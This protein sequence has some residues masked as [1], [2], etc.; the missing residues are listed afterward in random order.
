MLLSHF[1]GK[2]LNFDDLTAEID[3]GAIRAA[4]VTGGYRIK[5][6]NDETVARKF[7]KLD[8][9]VVQDMFASPLWDVATYQL[10]GGS[11]AER[12]GSYVNFAGR[13]QSAK[14]AIRP[15]VGAWAEGQLY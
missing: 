13:L 10:P 6:W 12:D 1:G 2:T 4:W 15:P 9:L 11:F 7:A 5:D 3:K 14:W 8:L